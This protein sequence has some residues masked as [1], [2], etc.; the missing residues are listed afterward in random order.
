MGSETT[1]RHFLSQ[2][3]QVSQVIGGVTFNGETLAP[4][5]TAIARA[6]RCNCIDLQTTLH[7]QMMSLDDAKH[8]VNTLRR[9][10][11]LTLA[12]LP[13]GLLVGG[14]IS[15]GIQDLSPDEW[16]P[17]CSASVTAC[18]HLMAMEGNDI[19]M[20]EHYITHYLHVL[21]DWAE[22]PSKY[23]SSAAYYAT[24]SFLLL[25]LVALHKLP[26]PLNTLERLT[27][28]TF[29]VKYAR[30][31]QD[32]IL[33]VT[34]LTHYGNALYDRH[35]LPEMLKTYVEADSHR[36]AIPDVLQSKVSLELAHAYAQHGMMK[37][38]LYALN[39][40][41]DLF[42]GS[43]EAPPF[44]QKDYGRHS[45]LL[46]SGLTYVDISRHAEKSKYTHQAANELAKVD[47][48]GTDRIPQRFLVEIRNQQ[49]LA[50][51]HDQ[52]FDD[53]ERYLKLGVEGAR[54]LKSEKRRQEAFS[55]LLAA[56]RA[57]PHESRKVLQ[58]AELFA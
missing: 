17:H 38:S 27:Q 32:K 20:V 4:M 31:S 34:A 23:Q 28:C 10:I 37:E 26:A 22:R 58:L 29:A 6:G 35:H 24:Q 36:S 12:A 21:M 48:P 54:S 13:V 15:K 11:L 5:L 57:W 33:L 53:F 16:L 49:A 40:A 45:L 42:P 39:Q 9:H 50:A 52:N 14:G 7:Q 44:L 46:F 18:W 51:V 1:R 56:G 25:G 19:L 2:V 47:H 8:P 41:Q 30:M 43:V 3:S 55:T